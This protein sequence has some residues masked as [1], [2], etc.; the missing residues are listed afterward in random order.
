VER[1]ETT[2]ADVFAAGGFIRRLDL[3]LRTP[4][5]IHIAVCQ[6]SDSV[7]AT[8]D[9]RLAAAAE[10]LGLAVEPRATP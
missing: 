10:N 5:A 6:R 1:I 3:N 8:F 4:D 9:R 2:S 7:L